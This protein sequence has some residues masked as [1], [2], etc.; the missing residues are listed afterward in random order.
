MS[1]GIMVATS[2]SPSSQQKMKDI[3]HS[4]SKTSKETISNDGMGALE[5]AADR[6]ISSSSNEYVVDNE[7]YVLI[8]G[9]YYKA[10]ADNKYVIDGETVFYVNNRSKIEKEKAAA[11]AKAA[12]QKESSDVVGT[13]LDIPVTPAQMMETLKRAQQA[14]AE[15]NR[16]LK[17]LDAQ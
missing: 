7:S 2:F 10:R 13:G 6:Q 1:A 9:K 14:T 5:R 8:K 16:A 3:L 15:R 17:E 4:I 11:A 12:S